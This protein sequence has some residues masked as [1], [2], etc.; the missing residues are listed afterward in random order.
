MY[1]GNNGKNKLGIMIHQSEQS[2]IG[3][4]LSDLILYYPNFYA[5][6]YM[7]SLEDSYLSMSNSDAF[8]NDTL[9]PDTLNQTITESS[10]L[11]HP[12]ISLP[13]SQT[14]PPFWL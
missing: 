3:Q 10:E 1:V 11:S 12:R 6:I 13:K 4:L 14:P 8:V 7:N 2:V 9:R 5:D